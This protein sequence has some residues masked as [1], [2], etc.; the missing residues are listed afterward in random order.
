[1]YL[2]HRWGVWDRVKG[3]DFELFHKQVGNKRV[4]GGG[5]GS[6]MDLFVILTLEEKDYVFE[7][8]LKECDDL[9]YGHVCPL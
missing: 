6:T 7:A 2:S 8:K 9:W 3:L 1:M 4:K 5:H